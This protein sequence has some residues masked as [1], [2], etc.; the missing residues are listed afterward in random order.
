M[1][2]NG[3]GPH[4]ETINETSRRPRLQKDKT[5]MSAIT[6]SSSMAVT[7]EKSELETSLQ[8]QTTAT[9]IGLELKSE[10]PSSLHQIKVKSQNEEDEKEPRLKVLGRNL[11]RLVCCPEKKDDVKTVTVVEPT[12]KPS[13]PLKEKPAKGAVKKGAKV[14]GGKG[15]GKGGKGKGGKD[16][17][18]D[19]KNEGKAEEKGVTA[20]EKG[21]KTERKGGES[22]E[23]KG[24]DT[25]EKGEGIAKGKGGEKGGKTGGKKGKK[26]KKLKD[27]PDDTARSDEDTL[28]EVANIELTRAPTK[29]QSDLRLTSTPIPGSAKGQKGVVSVPAGLLKPQDKSTEWTFLSCC[30][31]NR[32]PP[33]AEEEKVEVPAAP[34][35]S[36][37]KV[38]AKTAAKGK[39]GGKKDGGGPKKTGKKGGGGGKG[40]GKKK[41]VNENDLIERDLTDEQPA[42]DRAKTMPEREKTALNLQ[43]AEKVKVAVYIPTDKTNLQL[44]DTV[45]N[46]QPKLEKS[47][48]DVGVVRPPSSR[49]AS[50]VKQKG[51]KGKSEKKG[52][53]KANKGKEAG[54]KSSKDKK[55][56]KKKKK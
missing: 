38:G 21:D 44:K 11:S 9:S 29:M 1:L 49:P 39:G 27:L 8:R 17:G 45:I 30:F 35:P 5:S 2:T 53:K 18:K 52:N 16:G 43:D 56:S 48:T 40:G 47:K 31:G 55:G 51:G 10:R 7:R 15:K 33:P 37:K 19:E 41:D 20:E 14:K 4:V 54:T 26:E 12:E 25:G 50:S 24:E 42:L 46:G 13:S 28:T 36:K 34:V 32:S 23:E 3:I 22:K 6:R